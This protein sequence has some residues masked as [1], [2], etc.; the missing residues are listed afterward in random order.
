MSKNIAVVLIVLLLFV[1][2]FAFW[3][4]DRLNKIQDSLSE[5]HKLLEES[6][7]LIEKQ[8]NSISELEEQMKES[9]EK[10]QSLAEVDLK[11]QSEKIFTEKIT[12]YQQEIDDLRK[13][14]EETIEQSKAEY[15]D[16]ALLIAE[17]D[18]L[19][20]VLA[21]KEAQWQV[22]E[23]ENKK[24][25]VSLNEEINK[26][27]SNINLVN[28]KITELKQHLDSE[29]DIRKDL[30]EEISQYQ[31]RINSLQ[32]KLT[33]SQEDEAQ[34]QL[35]GQ[36][37]SS[38]E[39][40]E[41]EIEQ[42]D[43]VLEKIREEYKQLQTQLVNYEDKVDSL[44]GNMSSLEKDNKI[45]DEIQKDLLQLKEEKNN[46]EAILAEKESQLAANE[47]ESK[48]AI[49]SLEKLLVE[50]ETQWQSKAEESN[51]KIASLKEEIQRYDSNLKEI[52]SEMLSLKQGLRD[53]A[54]LKE[55]L[56]ERIVFLTDEI[57]YL[58][59]EIAG[60]RET[61]HSYLSVLN[62]LNAEKEELSKKVD[63]DIEIDQNEYQE[64][65]TQVNIYQDQIEELK[66]E[67][68]VIKDRD[69]LFNSEQVHQLQEKIEAL[70]KVF[71]EK[72]EEW[73]NQN[74][75]NRELIAYLKNQLKEYQEEIEVVKLDSSLFKEDISEQ[76]ELQ[77]ERIARIR[78]REEQIAELTSE[79]ERNAKKI[80]DYEGMI[81][82]L[83]AKLQEQKDLSYQEKQKLL[84][85]LTF[86]LE[87]RELIQNNF[88]QYRTKI[89][90]LES[91]IAELY[92]K[93]A[94][95]EKDESS[96]YYEIKKG[97]CLWN[98][99]KNRYN[100]GIAWTKIFEANQELI[101]NPDLIYPYQQWLL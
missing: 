83:R 49:E 80:A 54:S 64:L 13:M 16:I 70:E 22:G 93:M 53:E 57:A 75:E 7:E 76:V 21:E 27:E 42:R 43:A 39:T 50:K 88:N 94:S 37:Q 11:Q 1:T 95:L 34:V 77:Q 35:I 9:E 91:E 5:K 96:Q 6:K 68:A 36:L 15:Q 32:E 66:K 81:E 89:L 51:A 28:E 25:I 72:E 74:K 41:K 33:V 2:G 17:K 46:L 100:E 14:L 45:L 10:I 24:M 30:E 4:Y 73:G 97:D 26:Y 60:Y 52:G 101:K 62:Q 85:D 65:M 86:L 44:Q 92:N 61:E 12:Q 19:E 63:N 87:E 20:N 29:I 40:L 48:Q 3:N 99:A 67:L 18:R 69:E 47:K 84:D 71:S 98:I 38:K 78:D 55:K 90:R 31:D 59:D 56:Q 23:E 8:E 82:Q 58:K 79:I